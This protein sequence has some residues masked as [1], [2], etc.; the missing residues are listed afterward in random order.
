MSGG[1]VSCLALW[2]IMMGHKEKAHAITPN[3]SWAKDLEILGRK[4]MARHHSVC[5]LMGMMYGGPNESKC[6]FVPPSSY[7]LSRRV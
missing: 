2:A 5:S 6:H 7:L 1:R 4:T 3:D